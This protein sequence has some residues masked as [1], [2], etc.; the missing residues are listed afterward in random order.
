M[1]CCPLLQ[2]ALIP[3]DGLTWEDLADIDLIPM[4]K[5][6][7]QPAVT[8]CDEEHQ[9]W[10]IETA[11][12][13]QY[14]AW[15]WP[16]N[17]AV[18]LTIEVCVEGAEEVEHVICCYWYIINA[19]IGFVDGMFYDEADYP[20]AVEQ[21]FGSDVQLLLGPWGGCVDCETHNTYCEQKYNLA[22]PIGYAGS[23][24]KLSAL[25]RSCNLVTGCDTCVLPG[26]K[27]AVPAEVTIERSGSGCSPSLIAEFPICL[28]VS[29]DDIIWS[30]GQTGKVITYQ[31]RNEK[32]GS[33][34]GRTAEALVK[35]GKAAA[36]RDYLDH[37]AL[38]GF[39]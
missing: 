30:D 31:I 39:A 16:T 7:V 28:N 18:N 38:G 23:T 17:V 37:M 5:L 26:T 6:T 13:L 15:L 27:E 20:A 22:P 2:S 11:N 35:E 19:P 3:V 29:E 36:V 14:N 12:C 1:L 8:T 25:A 34:G 21:F 9:C 4:P 24:Y 32:P 33:F 10:E